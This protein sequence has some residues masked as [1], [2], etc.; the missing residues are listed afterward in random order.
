MIFYPIPDHS[1]A[2]YYQFRIFSI[3]RYGALPPFHQ[4][5]LLVGTV[6]HYI[7]GIPHLI[8]AL[9]DDPVYRGTTVMQHLYFIPCVDIL[10]LQIEELLHRVRLN[11]SPF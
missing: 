5:I 7:D 3:R 9:Q 11:H 8:D 1:S 6:Q 4:R 10:V 2:V